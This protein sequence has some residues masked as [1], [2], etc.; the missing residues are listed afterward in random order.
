MLLWM[1]GPGEWYV[2]LIAIYIICRSAL[3]R[4]EPKE[5]G[6]GSA[7]VWQPVLMVYWRTESFQ[8]LQRGTL[9]L[10]YGLIS[11]PQPCT[12]RKIQ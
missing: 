7:A 10:A 8:V 2:R 6:A 5:R 4:S 9:K 1:Y 3:P 12:Y 11:T